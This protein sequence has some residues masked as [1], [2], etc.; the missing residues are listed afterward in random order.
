MFNVVSS[1]LWLSTRAG[2]NADVGCLRKAYLDRL[3]EFEQDATGTEVAMGKIRKF[4]VVASMLA[5]NA[6]ITSINAHASDDLC[7]GILTDTG[8]A[9][10]A[11]GHLYQVGLPGTP[12]PEELTCLFNESSEVGKQILRICVNGEGCR[13]RG[14]F[15]I[16]RAP[17][18]EEGGGGVLRTVSATTSIMF[19]PAKCEE[20]MVLA[21]GKAACMR[22]TLS[23]N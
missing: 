11:K 6:P 4:I 8:P 7:E 16:A 14:A 21:S 15:K 19:V 5:L 22:K 18:N 17:T 9:Y 13:I 3:E 20:T 2:C 12:Q 1:D 10:R 23:S